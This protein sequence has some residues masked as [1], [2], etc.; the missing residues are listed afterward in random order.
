MRPSLLL[1]RIVST[2]AIFHAPETRART[3]ALRLARA[4]A[5]GCR[6]RGVAHV[7]AAARLEHFAACLDAI[8][9]P[10]DEATFSRLRAAYGGWSASSSS[11]TWRE[12]ETFRLTDLLPPLLQAVAGYQFRAT[13]TPA[14]ALPR[15]LGAAGD[16]LCGCNC[17]G[18]AWSVLEAASAVTDRVT[19]SR[20]AHDAAWRALRNA[21]EPVCARDGRDLG[22]AVA[23]NG[24]L[25]PGDVLMIWH[26][27]EGQG[28]YLDHVAIFIDDDLHFSPRG[29]ADGSR[30]RRGGDVSATLRP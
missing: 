2:A 21:T 19:I 9:E 10:T 24:R 17:W 13:T 25:R 7:D 4:D 16:V 1:A 26:E 15:A 5:L 30:Q 3:H 11:V 14:V 23:R 22:D 6:Y 28:R 8:F 12:G 18:F 20:G 29:S 27:N